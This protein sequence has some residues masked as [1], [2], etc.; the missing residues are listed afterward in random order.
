[1]SGRLRLEAL[2]LVWV[3]VTKTYALEGSL[4]GIWVALAS[5][6]DAMQV[7][8]ARWNGTTLILIRRRRPQLSVAIYALRAFSVL[9]TN[10]I[11]QQTRFIPHSPQ[12]LN[13]AAAHHPRYT[14]TSPMQTHGHSRSLGSV[15][16][17][18][19]GTPSPPQV[20]QIPFDSVQEGEQTVAS[21]QRPASSPSQFEPG[22]RPLS[23]IGLA[24]PN[25]YHT[26]EQRQ[27]Y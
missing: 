8:K 1:M 17:D 13:F 7:R 27:G 18:R 10:S 14:L 4:Q 9:L 15:V 2:A 21:S 23:C 3:G 11:R 20:Q 16:V 5:Q 6:M 19:L 12:S 26:W 22:A 25:P 24:A